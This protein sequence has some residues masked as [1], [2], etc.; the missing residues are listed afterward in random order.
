MQD[1]P[2]ADIYTRLGRAEHNQTEISKELAH[3]CREFGE[4]KAGLNGTDPLKERVARL[5]SRW[6]RI[7]GA[8]IAL[9]VVY[10][11]VEGLKALF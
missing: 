7:V 5:E 10:G 11:A 3:L 9:G 1:E 2:L 4:L 6:Q 8:I